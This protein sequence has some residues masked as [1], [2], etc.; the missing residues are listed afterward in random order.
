MDGEDA[1]EQIRIAPEDVK[2]TFM[3]TPDGT[4]ES[5]LVAMAKFGHGMYGMTYQNPG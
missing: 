1:Y 5:L 4:I 2:H 3:A